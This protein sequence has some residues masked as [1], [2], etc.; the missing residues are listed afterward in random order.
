MRAVN[1]LGLRLPQKPQKHA[2]KYAQ[3]LK[4]RRIGNLTDGRY[5]GYITP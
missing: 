4:C 3:T 1:A 2:E 5:I